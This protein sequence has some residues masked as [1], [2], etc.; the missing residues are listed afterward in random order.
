MKLLFK[1]YILAFALLS[2]TSANAVTIKWLHLNAE[3]SPNMPGILKAVAEYEAKTGNKVELQYLENESFK[4]KLPTML[5]SDDRPDIFYSWSGGVM[6]DQARAGFLRDI[7]GVVS[8]DYLS[9]LSA[10]AANAF[11]FE[12]QRVGIPTHVAQVAWWYNKELV[13]QAGVDVSKI[14]YW[15][16][17]LEVVKQIKSAGI[18]PICL[19][20][21]DKWPVHFIWTHLH[22]RNGGKDLFLE[23]LNNGGWGRPEYVKSGEQMLELVALDPFQNGYLAATWPDQAGLFG[24]GKCAMALMGNWM[25]GAQ[26]SNSASGE[27]L[28][29]GNMGMFNMPATKGGLGDPGDTLGGI[30]GWLFS[31]S[32]PDEA[33]ELIMHYVSKEIQSEDAANGVY[34]PVVKGADTSIKNP[35][36][37]QVAGN[38]ANSKY[39]QIFYDQFLGADIG[40]VV[41]DVSTDLAAGIISP[42]EATA[43]VQEAWEF[44]Q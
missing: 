19:G 13:N 8:D 17:L 7:S 12:E 35:F 5:Q 29:D 21:K 41:N 34:I 44:N 26:A 14:V 6:Y 28:G 39:H 32:A 18:T 20:G 22:I 10:A 3:N 24:D 25:Y 37:K 4:A 42:E 11:T 15:E 9:T 27:G 31:S 1:I 40:R 30:N 23:S 36:L 16:D 43:Q 38:I 2:F 33:V